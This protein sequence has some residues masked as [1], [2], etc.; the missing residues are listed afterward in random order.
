LGLTICHDLITR[1]GG[2]IEVESHP[3]KG[4]TFIIT[5]P[6]AQTPTPV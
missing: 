1:A 3:G 4:A 5:L 2:T 6:R